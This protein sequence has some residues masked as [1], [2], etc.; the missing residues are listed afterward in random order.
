V[1]ADDY[2]CSPIEAARYNVRETLPIA[3]GKICEGDNRHDR[4][5][6]G[7]DEADQRFEIELSVE[8]GVITRQKGESYIL[9]TL[10]DTLSALVGDSRVVISC[11]KLLTGR[12][13]N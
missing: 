2:I 3:T 7:C 10:S 1:G 9:E 6:V 4:I 13:M 5:R 12:S 8:S 11:L